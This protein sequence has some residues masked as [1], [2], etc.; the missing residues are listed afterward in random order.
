M[1]AAIREVGEAGGKVLDDNAASFTIEL[2]GTGG[3][4]DE[5]VD[6]MAVRGDLLAVVRSGPMAIARGHRVLSAT[7]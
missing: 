1:D 2:T 5:F 4:I 7:A 6:N 3:V